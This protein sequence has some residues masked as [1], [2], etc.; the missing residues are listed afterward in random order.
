MTAARLR[1]VPVMLVRRGMHYVTDDGI[2]LD[3]L[4]PDEPLLADGTNDVNE[5]SVVMRLTYRCG[6]C[7]RP[8]RML[9]TG[10]A[11]AQSEARMLGC[12]RCRTHIWRGHGIADTLCTMATTHERW[13]RVLRG[14]VIIPAAAFLVPF[15]IV[16]LLFY[17]APAVLAEGRMKTVIPITVI[18][19]YFAIYFLCRQYTLAGHRISTGRAVVLLFSSGYLTLQGA[20]CGSSQ[21]AG[22]GHGPLRAS[23]FAAQRQLY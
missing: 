23:V 15:I 14:G 21:G 5:N 10:D 9:F 13:N 22:D 20:M 16:T 2:T 12:D 4:G 11:G 17:L 1:R 6:A 3:A 18:V 7:A 8:F 19:T